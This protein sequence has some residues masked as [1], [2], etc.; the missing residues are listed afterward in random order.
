MGR[1]LLPNIF[2]IRLALYSSTDPTLHIKTLTSL[3]YMNTNLSVGLPA[4]PHTD[5]SLHSAAKIV[6]MKTRSQHTPQL[7]LKTCLWLPKVAH[8]WAPT[9]SAASGSHLPFT[10]HPL[11]TPPFCSSNH[12][13]LIWLRTFVF[14]VYFCL[15]HFSPEGSTLLT[16]QA[17]LKCHLLRGFPDCSTERIIPALPSLPKPLWE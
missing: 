11:A 3:V 1:L 13:G 14:A 16:C 6:Y 8:S 17:E 15:E 2:Q 9:A 4:C 5:S 10:L 12:Q 7:W